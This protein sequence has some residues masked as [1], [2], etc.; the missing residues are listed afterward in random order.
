MAHESCSYVR[1]KAK[2]RHTK[3]S[4]VTLLCGLCSGCRCPRGQHASL[5][6]VA[7]SSAYGPSERLA[8]SVSVLVCNRPVLGC[9]LH[10]RY[11]RAALTAHRCLFT[12]CQTSS[13]GSTLHKTGRSSSGA[14]SLSRASDSWRKPARTRGVYLA[15]RRAG[16]ST[17]LPGACER[18]ESYLHKQ[19]VGQDI[20]VRQ[21]VSAVCAHIDTPEPQKPLV[22][23][24]HGPPGV[25]KTFTHLL[26]ARAL[27]NRDPEAVTQCPGMGCTGYKVRTRA[28]GR[29]HLRARTPI[30]CGASVRASSRAS[31]TSVVTRILQPGSVLADGPCYQAAAH[32]H[33]AVSVS[34]RGTEMWVRI[35]VRCV[36]CPCYAGCV[37]L[38]LSTRRQTT[39]ARRSKG[40]HT[41]THT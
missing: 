41:V 22:I 1:R 26:M 34:E 13:S 7:P 2:A 25:G 12:P 20:A 32:Q 15:A 9:V 38:R 28:L 18:L 29:N 11:V 19:L 40:G 23:S 10:A 16:T 3:S 17:F 5:A 8:C 33:S 37:R 21:L 36:T 4:T 14:H 35:T 24:V 27:Y 6:A 31:T 39:A 30:S